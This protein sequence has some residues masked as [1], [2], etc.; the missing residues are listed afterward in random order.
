MICKSLRFIIHADPYYAQVA[1]LISP[2]RAMMER[3]L[4]QL[5]SEK[6][7]RKWI[8]DLYDKR[9][10][11]TIGGFVGRSDTKP[12]SLVMY[13]GEMPLSVE[14]KEVLAHEIFHCVEMIMKRA[15]MPHHTKY[16]SEAYAYLIGSLTNQVNYYVHEY[17]CRV[18]NAQD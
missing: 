16:S 2:T 5:V 17:A 6:R 7:A 3:F 8:R 14:G 10:G 18:L 11:S 1:V 9:S 12:N 4:P 13:L 15:G